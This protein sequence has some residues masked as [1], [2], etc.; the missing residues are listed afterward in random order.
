MAEGAAPLSGSRPTAQA[1]FQAWL[2]VFGEAEDADRRQ[3]AQAAI[4]Q[5]LLAHGQVFRRL[6]RI[7]DYEER[8]DLAQEILAHALRQL[9]WL[10]TRFGPAAHLGRY[11]QMCV[12]HVLTRRAL[13]PPRVSLDTVDVAGAPAESLTALEHAERTALARGLATAL[14]AF[15]GT[16]AGR[17]GPQAVQWFEAAFGAGLSDAAIARE[18]RVTREHVARTLGQI[19]RDPVMRA[20]I[21]RYY[22][23]RLACSLA[24]A[25]AA[26]AAVD[27]RRADPLRKLLQALCTVVTHQEDTPH[28]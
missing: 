27:P 28:G 4:A 5:L 12:T 17:W 24:D 1:Q 26:I 19:V 13:P 2:Q 7:P 20:W 14:R 15:V 11:L 3:H 10:W 8:R 6:G 18:A 16:Q 21:A 22:H 9:P 25:L 23:E